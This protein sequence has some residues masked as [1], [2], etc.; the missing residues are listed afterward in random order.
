MLTLHGHSSHTWPYWA[1]YARLCLVYPLHHIFS[2]SQKFLTFQ[3]LVIS[4]FDY[5]DVIYISALNQHLLNRVQRIQNSC[6]HF[7]YCVRK[8]NHY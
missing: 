1:A 2:C 4:L 8:Y 7:S 5:A 3:L 6:L